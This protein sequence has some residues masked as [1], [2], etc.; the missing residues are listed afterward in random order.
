MNEA[1]ATTPREDCT[2]AR[3]KYT[4]IK[5]NQAGSPRAGKGYD[6][7]ANVLTGQS[8]KPRRP[9]PRNDT[10]PILYIT[11]IYSHA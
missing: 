8:G 9:R 10:L 11:V 7:G 5:R 4:L 1:L 6:N 2:P 3:R